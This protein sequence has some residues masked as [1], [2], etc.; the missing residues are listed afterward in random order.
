MSFLAMP[1]FL[2]WKAKYF[3]PRT[4]AKIWHVKEH[5]VGP[6]PVFLLNRQFC[7]RLWT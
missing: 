2:A 3:C 1:F 4:D 5:L 7:V 6:I